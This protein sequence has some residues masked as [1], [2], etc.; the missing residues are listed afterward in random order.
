MAQRKGRRKCI[1]RADTCV[2]VALDRHP[3]CLP[4]HWNPYSSAVVSLH[5]S[6]WPALAGYHLIKVW[7]ERY[8]HMGGVGG[9]G[10]GGG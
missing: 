2:S 1:M 4:C 6:V 5:S 3:C 7:T 10:G 8:D 9:G